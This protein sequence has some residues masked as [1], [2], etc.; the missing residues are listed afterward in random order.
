MTLKGQI[1]LTGYFEKRVEQKS[2]L[3]RNLEQQ[4]LVMYVYGETGLKENTQL[5]L[6]PWKGNLY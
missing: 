1:R 5:M 4:E 3:V 2:S 6:K